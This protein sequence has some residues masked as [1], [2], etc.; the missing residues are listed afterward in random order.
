MIGEEPDGPRHRVED[1]AQPVLE[2][3]GSVLSE[4][5][6]RR[7]ASPQPNL[8][9]PPV[10]RCPCLRALGMTPV[11]ETRCTRS[12]LGTASSNER[13]HVRI[14]ALEGVEHAA[15][16]G[17]VGREEMDLRHGLSREQAEKWL[18]QI[19]ERFD[20]VLDEIQ[21]Q[22]RPRSRC[23]LLLGG[24]EASSSQTLEPQ[25]LLCGPRSHCARAFDADGRSL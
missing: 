4:P 15:K 14:S 2:A 19:L 11:P 20:F 8:R 25:E 18:Q 21:I 9:R 6:W 10:G 17:A 3:F 7:Y 23:S 5:A 16:L 1:R 22:T 13:A 24:E 12:K